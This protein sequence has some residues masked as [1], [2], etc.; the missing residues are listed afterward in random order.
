MMLPT[1]QPL[2]GRPGEQVKPTLTQDGELC[3]LLAKLQVGL[4][5]S[6]QSVLLKLGVILE[7]AIHASPVPGSWLVP[8]KDI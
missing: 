5:V 8:G 4:N 6:T 7:L 3:T 2:Q 1:Q